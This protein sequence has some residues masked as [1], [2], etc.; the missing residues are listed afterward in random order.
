MTPKLFSRQIEGLLSIPAEFM[1]ISRYLQGAMNE[2]KI[3]LTFDDGY[4]S[5]FHYAFPLL[6]RFDIKATLFINPA[7][8]GQF[9]TWDVNLGYLRFR[10]MNWQQV[11]QLQEN[12]WEIGIH[13]FSH[14]DL[15]RLHE[16]DISRDITLALGIMNRR[17][18][19]NCRVISFPFGNVNETV[20]RVCREHGLTAGLT[21]S[22]RPSDVD[23]AFAITRLGVYPFDGCRS[24]NHK[25]LRGG[26]TAQRM[27]QRVMDVCSDM[28]VFVKQKNWNLN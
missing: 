17:L 16:A 8:V 3:A 2:N 11:Q 28:T 1:T 13:G 4:E 10:H 20:E 9:N 25:A 18:R 12:G 5:V 23:P 7:F 24:L 14:H 15:S 6:R 27:M 22:R 19:S 21:M 26:T